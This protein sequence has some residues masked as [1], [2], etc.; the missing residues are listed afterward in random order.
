MNALTEQLLETLWDGDPTFGEVESRLK[1]QCRSMSAAEAAVIGR[2]LLLRRHALHTKIF[3]LAA[4]LASDGTAG[5]DGFMD[6]T[7]CVALLPEERYQRIVNNPDELAADPVSTNF[8]ECYLVSEVCSVF[9]C[10]LLEEDGDDELLLYLVLGEDEIDWSGM[11]SATEADAA[12]FLPRLHS[13][14]GHLLSLP[15]P[16]R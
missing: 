16:S 6:F 14:S 5:N 3:K 2:D 11:D 1:E 12:Q 10:A 8:E 15:K 4:F 9:D 7:D 13:K